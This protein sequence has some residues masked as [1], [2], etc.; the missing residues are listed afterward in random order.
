MRI[1]KRFLVNGAIMSVTSF[2]LKGIAI[3]F[4]AFVSRRLGADGMGLFTLIM[5]VYG[6]SVTVAASGVNLA[7]T[8]MCAERL[9]ENDKAGAMAAMRRC[10]AYALLCGCSAFVLLFFGAEY[11]AVSWL[12]DERCTESLKFLAVSLPF[13]ASSNVLHG[14][15]TAVRK[16]IKSAACQ[17]FEQLFKTAFCVWALLYL[18]PE[19]I[20]Y[21]C[22]ALVGGGALAEFLSF[23][24]ALI[25][26]LADRKAKNRM[27][28]R[29]KGKRLT[30]EM[31]SITVP[32]ALAAYARSGLSTLE[33]IL[34]P[35]GLSKNPITADTALA[36]YGVLCGMVM[37]VVM[38]PTALLYSFTGLLIPEFAEAS[39]VRNTARIRSMTS[40]ALGLTVIFS[41]GCAAVMWRFSSELGI[42]IYDNADAGIF[43]GVMAPLI[44]VMYLD[45]AVDAILKGMGE[46]VYCMKVNIADAALCTLLVYILCPIIGIWGYILTIYIAEI[47]NFTLSF[48]KLTKLGAVR[49]NTVRRFVMPCICAVAA[50]LSLKIIPRHHNVG[51]V[52][53][54]WGIVVTIAV[55]CALLYV[56]GTVSKKDVEFVRCF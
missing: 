6:L 19:G 30:V 36:T 12:G 39:T 41:V 3:A 45:H 54:V 29:E 48:Y 8:R 15:F 5:S 32:V 31:L 18:V 40:R 34:I 22:M 14:Y 24:L 21:A 27:I 7:A 17:I 33:H 13:I 10:L 43:I 2:A 50:V 28:S 35:K 23:I 46:Q 55:Y 11:V 26:Y 56:T 47:M 4:N 38:F 1:L 9:G 20:E 52:G 49:M 37:P 53:V 51:L 42:L 44:P 25:L 16:V